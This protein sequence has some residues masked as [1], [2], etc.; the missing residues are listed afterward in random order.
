MQLKN[1]RVLLT[2]ASGGIGRELAFELA[3]HGA[4]VLLSGRKTLVLDNIANAIINLG[5]QARILPCDLSAAGGPQRLIEQA[6]RDGATLD[7]VISCAGISHFGMT[8][9]LGSEQLNQLLRT[10]VVAPM[11]LAQAVL[12]VFKAQGR[13]LIVNVG[14]IF[15][16]IGFPCFSAYSASKFALR[17]FSEAL[18]R[19]LQGSGVDVLYVAPRY[20]RTAINEGAVSRMADAVAMKQDEP[21]RVAKAI[22]DAIRGNAR[23]RYLGWPERFFVKLNAL[24]PRLVDKGLREQG[25]RMRPFAL[26]GS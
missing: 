16:S 26:S 12:P 11:Q 24:F 1:Q 6:T 3:Q 8:E 7:I 19:E 21:Q 20:T 18:R 2:G 22:A 10:N 25:R 17:G 13:G 9:D 14:S 5:G 4:T 15:G 23:E